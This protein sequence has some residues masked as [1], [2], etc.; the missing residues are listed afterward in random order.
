MERFPKYLCRNFPKGID[1]DREMVYNK[2]RKSSNDRNK[3]LKGNFRKPIDFIVNYN[4]II[5]ARKGG[6][7]DAQDR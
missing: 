6:G 4:V 1:K 3:N 5:E 7:E 2:H